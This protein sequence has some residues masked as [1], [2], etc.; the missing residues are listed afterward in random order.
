VPN[1]I[2]NPTAQYAFGSCKT[3]LYHC[4]ACLHEKYKKAAMRV[5]IKLDVSVPQQ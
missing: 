5:Q 4:K 2:A 3:G 1:I